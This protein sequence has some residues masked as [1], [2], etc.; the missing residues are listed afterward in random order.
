MT[1]TAALLLAVSLAALLPPPISE[2]AI[3][4]RS[5]EGWSI[6]GDEG[7]ELEK[8][9]A[10]QMGKAESLEA[11]GKTAAAITSYQN[12]VRHFSLS[13][14][15]PKAQRKVGILQEKTGHYEEAYASYQKYLTKYPKGDDFGSVVEA[16]YRI[17]KLFLEGA[18]RR[19]FGVPVASS[20]EKAQEMF[21]GIVKN[22][23]FSKWAP[24]AQFNAGQALEKGN[25]LPEAIAAYQQVVS[26]Y[27]NDAIADNALYQI[28]YIRMRQYREGSYDKADAQK[29]REA[30]EEYMNRYPDSEKV[31]QAK[32]NIASLQGGQTKGTLQI[33]KFYDKTKQ[34]KAAVI[35][36]NDVI[37]SQPGTPDSDFAKNRIEELKTQFGADVLTAGPT[38][39]ENGARAAE[40]RKMQAKVDVSSRP[41]YVGP[42]VTVP[43]APV[44]T[45]PGKPKLRTS[46]DNIGPVPAVEPSL[47]EQPSPLKPSDPGL[48]LPPPPQ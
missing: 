34:Y 48:P 47:P 19:V 29:A 18:K 5:N 21:E 12:L 4:Y 16:M 7:S 37:K 46:P 40:K 45:A 24:L 36:Y 38:K 42:P 8:T 41:D 22:A 32:E 39:A 1:K 2:A 15:A 31:A 43:E 44:E 23:P 9:A 25:K 20:M 13:V 35:Y 27:P 26:R 17:A 11:E 10:D 3:I 6:E 30:F 14:L 33:A 28:G